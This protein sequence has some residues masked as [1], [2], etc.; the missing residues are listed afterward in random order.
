MCEGF[1]SYTLLDEQWETGTVPVPIHKK[2]K[3]KHWD[4]IKALEYPQFHSW[5]L[6][7][8]RNKLANEIKTSSLCWHWCPYATSPTALWR[9]PS[10]YITNKPQK[11]AWSNQCFIL[12]KYSRKSFTISRVWN[13]RMWSKQLLEIIYIPKSVLGSIW[14]KLHS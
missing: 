5:N 4:I 10:P 1:V 8:E 7:P 14:S 13:S 9:S 11:R 12:L 3:P 6:R 2:Q